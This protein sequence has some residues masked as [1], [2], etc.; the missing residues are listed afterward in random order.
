[1]AVNLFTGATNNNWGT[2]TNWSQGT[3]PIQGDGHVTTFDVTS[4]N[5]TVNISGSTMDS[6]NFSGY[7]NTISINNGIVV[8][9]DLTFGSGMSVAGTSTIQ[10]ATSCSITCNGFIFPNSF[11]FGGTS[12]TYVLQDNFYCSGTI[13]LAGITSLTI[14]DNGT[15]KIIYASGNISVGVAGSSGTAKFIMNGTGTLTSPTGTIDHDFEINT[16]GT[17]TF[18][19]SVKISGSLFKYTAGTVDV[20]TNNSTFYLGKSGSFNSIDAAGLDF[21]NFQFATDQIITLLD[22]LNIHGSAVSISSTEVNGFNIYINDGIVNIGG[23]TGAWL[24]GTTKLIL[25]G[26]STISGSTGSIRLDTDINSTGTITITGTFNYSVGTLT[27][28]SGT[29]VTTSSIFRPFNC[30]LDVDGINWDQVFTISNGTITLLSPLNVTTQLTNTATVT[31]NG[32]II[33]LSGILSLGGSTPLLGT[34]ELRF[35]GSSPSWIGG[36]GILRLNTFIDCSGTFSMTGTSSSPN[37][38]ETGTLTYVSG[39][40]NC[41]SSYLDLKTSGSTLNVDGMLLGDIV[42]K[43]GTLTLNSKLTALGTL[44]LC[45]T[46]SVIFSGNFGWEVGTMLCTTINRNITLKAGNTYIINNSMKII[47]TGNAASQRIRILSNLASSY[48]Y[49][50][51]AINATSLNKYC[52]A[53]DIDSSGGRLIY[54]DKGVLLRTIN[55]YISNP[56]AFAFF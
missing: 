15:S 8:N 40:T 38:Y 32:S 36:T 48:A 24:V 22:D 13:S 26:D 29:V 17:I 10:V 6:L 2:N 4:P 53:T 51:L 11:V 45:S 41:S 50:N 12:Q 44:T 54:T 14:N 43:Q 35:I 7:V 20:D 34:S 30:T 23:G 3:V 39:T 49:L 21:N 9:G 25:T 52:N 56:D 18:G 16:T 5:C 55:W 19:S 46:S 1:M 28:I 47:G 33:Y 27:Y 42:F 31:Y 37:N